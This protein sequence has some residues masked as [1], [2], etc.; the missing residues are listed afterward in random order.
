MAVVNVILDYVLIFGHWGFPKLGIAG[1]GIASTTAEASAL[2]YFLI[3]TFRNTRVKEYDLFRL[4]KPAMG[5]HQKY[6]WRFCFCDVADGSFFGVLVR[7][8]YVY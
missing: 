6:A 2:L 4:V 7:V 5:N 3:V 8:F 1:A